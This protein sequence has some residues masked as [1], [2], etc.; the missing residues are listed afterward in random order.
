MSMD[1]SGYTSIIST[2]IVWPSGLA[3]DYQ[4]QT[5][6]WSDA[7]LDRLESS[8]FNGQNRLILLERRFIFYPYGLAYFNGTLYWGDW[9]VG[10]VYKLTVADPEDHNYVWPVPEME[11][12]G[13]KVVSKT[14]QPPGIYTR[15]H[16]LYYI[17]IC[18]YSLVPGVSFESLYKPDAPKTTTV[19]I[20]DTRT[21]ML[22]CN[23]VGLVA[24]TP[25]TR[26]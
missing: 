19:H 8:D 20:S 10:F 18:I 4:S 22:H 9:V 2:D 13:I 1:G 21:D 3:I 12:T 15:I 23:K 5:L 11:P 17:Y 24:E 6:F 7:H 14:N 25:G 16:I 26:L